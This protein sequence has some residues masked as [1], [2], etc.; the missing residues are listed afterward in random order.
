MP[1]SNGT[2]CR[3]SGLVV[4]C[5]VLQGTPRQS[6]LVSVLMKA[7]RRAVDRGSEQRSDECDTAGE[8]IA[9]AVDVALLRPHRAGH[10]PVFRPI[11]HQCAQWG[12]LVT[13]DRFKSDFPQGMRL[14]DLGE[15]LLVRAPSVTTVVDRLERSGLVTRNPAGRFGGAKLV[16]LTASGQ[17]LVARVAS[18]HGRQVH[19]FL[20]VCPLASGNGFNAFC[21]GWL[22]ISKRFWRVRPLNGKSW[23]A[24]C[25]CCGQG[26]QKGVIRKPT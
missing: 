2:H 11:W 25:F 4:T 1:S 21:F 20:P 15:L 19:P 9:T 7:R 12:V 22:L 13:L 10:E 26:R 3:T 16:R 8:R 6:H 17:Q 23:P 18:V 14:S 5:G 24:D